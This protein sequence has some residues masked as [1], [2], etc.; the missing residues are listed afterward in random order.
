[1][2]Y[3][4]HQR[5]IIAD[6]SEKNLVEENKTQKLKKSAIYKEISRNIDLLLEKKLNRW[7]GIFAGTHFCL[8]KPI[9]QHIFPFD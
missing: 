9:I 1:M 5:M 7:K 2:K 3:H 6:F 4:W 8:R